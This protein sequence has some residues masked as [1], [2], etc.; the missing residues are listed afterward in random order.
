MTTVHAGPRSFR[1]GAD[2]L[3]REALF[4]Q[5]GSLVGAVVLGF[6]SVAMRDATGAE[7]GILLRA[8][9]LTAVAVMA[10][11]VIPWSRVPE[12]FHVLV[13]F[14][15]LGAVYLVQSATGGPYSSYGQLALLPV[16]WVA[17]F[18]RPRE[19]GLVVLGA[20]VALGA[21]VVVAGGNV[22]DWARLATLL[23]VGTGMAL[24]VYRFF[25]GLRHQ[26]TRLQVLAGTDPLTGA[27]NRRAWDQELA[28]ALIRA[29]RDGRP[30]C[31]A[32]VDLDDFK[33]FND[34][35]GHQ[36]GDRLLRQV[37]GAW[38]NQ[39]RASDILARIGGDEF[40]ILLPG[41][42]LDMAA[43]IV[44]RLRDSVPAARCSIGVAEWDHREPVERLVARV[45]AALYEA[46][47]AG[48]DRV[49]ILPETGSTGVLPDRDAAGGPQGPDG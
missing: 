45:D 5:V 9:T 21:P 8:S 22:H 10:I 44:R 4:R 25:D 24:L 49:V 12:A 33:G 6:L 19:L 34:S 23:S 17:V 20:G 31:V 1:R 46:K 29:T 35:N 40:G 3:S 7:G 15:Y 11:M 47:A 38:Q 32:L 42:P 2:P 13:P 39:L 37:A 36:A 14:A 16:F 28:G 18:G 41:C 26:T 48:R 27:A 30:V 43:T